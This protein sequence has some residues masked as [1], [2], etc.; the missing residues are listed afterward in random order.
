MGGILIFGV[1]S[2]LPMICKDFLVIAQFQASSST[3]AVN[4]LKAPAIQPWEEPYIFMGIDDAVMTNRTENLVAY[5][6]QRID[7]QIFSSRKGSQQ[8]RSRPLWSF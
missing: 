7:T 6:I 8:L 5:P 3:A 1:V 2:G 4:T